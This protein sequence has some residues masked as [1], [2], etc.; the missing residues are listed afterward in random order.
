MQSIIMQSEI[1]SNLVS[2]KENFKW[3]TDS[4]KQIDTD[5][6]KLQNYKREYSRYYLHTELEE[7]FNSES[8]SKLGKK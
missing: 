1:K 8:K 3:F 4:I 2:S 5:I 6:E 7:L